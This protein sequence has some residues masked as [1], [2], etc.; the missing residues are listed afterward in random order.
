MGKTQLP[1]GYSAE[2]I[3]I[4]RSAEDLI[5]EINDLQNEIEA[6]TRP[7]LP[8]KPADEA[9]VEVRHLAS[10]F[11]DWTLLVRD[12]EDRLA[13]RAAG[14][15]DRSGDNQHV[16]DL[17]LAVRPAHRRRGIGR[18]LLAESARAATDAGAN[19][20]IC[21]SDSAVAAA[22]PFA[23]SAG[24]ELALLERESDLVLS[25]VDW[26]MVD[27][28]V[29]EGPGRAPD[30]ALEFVEGLYPEALYDDVIAWQDVMN[31]APR[32]QLQVND[33]FGTREKLAESEARFA[34]SSR[35]RLEFLARH[36]PTGEC[37]GGTALHFDPWT[38]TVLWQ[39]ATAVHPNHRGHALGKWL[40][41][42]MLQQARQRYPGVETVR[43]G[44]AY[45][46]DAMIGINDKLGFRETRAFM[47]WQAKAPEV[48]AKVGE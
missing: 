29:A 47:S 6:E 34:A 15:V 17:I 8:G 7:E 16:F 45:S 42:A 41:A 44:N 5:A 3:E 38:P 48:L 4:R 35:N 13:A 32:E 19:L 18:W 25:G 33:D 30:Y 31:T 26:D 1:Q 20:L 43:T 23:R 27:R 21:W 10:Y 37:V 40:K 12:S 39:G 46:N 14:L 2:R 24:F 11:E 9:V 36:V 28:W 22:E